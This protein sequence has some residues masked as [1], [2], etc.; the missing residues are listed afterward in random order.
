[1]MGLIEVPADARFTNVGLACGRHGLLI[2]GMARHGFVGRAG[3]P[4][5]APSR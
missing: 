1:M 4:I 2:V 5:S 3:A